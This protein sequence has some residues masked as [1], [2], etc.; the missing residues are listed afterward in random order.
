MNNILIS[1]PHD[2][3]LQFTPAG[4]KK[5][6]IC[7]V[8]QQ[9]KA[10]TDQNSIL[11]NNTMNF[12]QTTGNHATTVEIRCPVCKQCV[13]NNNVCQ[14]PR[15]PLTLITI[16]GNG[17]V[18]Y[19]TLDH[20]IN[21]YSHNVVRN[22]PQRSTVDDVSITN[23]LYQSIE[24]CFSQQPRFPLSPVTVE[25]NESVILPSGKQFKHASLVKLDTTRSHE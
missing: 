11:E 9:Y 19:I 6:A 7:V 1:P 16:E 20:T 14:Q 25:G 24:G 2:I 17:N 3:F 4:G 10:L 8:R 22:V 21:S 15:Q 5:D 18:Q 12:H 13:T 23:N